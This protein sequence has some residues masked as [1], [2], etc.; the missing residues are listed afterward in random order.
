MHSN[1]EVINRAN[2]F[3]YFAHVS[4]TVKQQTWKFAIKYMDRTNNTTPHTYKLSHSTKLLIDTF[5]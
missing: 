3:N 2:F 5:E 4:D 1:N